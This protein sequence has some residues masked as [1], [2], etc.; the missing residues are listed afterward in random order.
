NRPKA[1][2]VAIDFGLPDIL[3]I[4]LQRQNSRH[5]IERLHALGKA[6]DFYLYDA[7]GFGGFLL[8]IGKMRGH[9][10]LQVVDVVHEDAID[11]IHGGI[12]VARHGDVDEEHWPVAATCHETLAMLFAEDGNR[13]AGRSD[14]D[15]GLI[16][17]VVE[18]FKTK[19]TAI[20]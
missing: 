20:K 8:A 18:L 2:A 4:F 17:S 1:A 9:N 7:L 6:L 3:K 10:L 14:D 15:I 19:R 11:I 16:C 5:D 12:Y 13:R